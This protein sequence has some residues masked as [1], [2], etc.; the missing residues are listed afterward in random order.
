[1]CAEAIDE[2]L[3]ELTLSIHLPEN[4]EPIVRH[5]LDDQRELSDLGCGNH[6]AA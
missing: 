3:V 5:M 1:V 6:A 4:W 2:Q